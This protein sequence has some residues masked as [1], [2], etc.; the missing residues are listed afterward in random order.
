MSGGG[1]GKH[2]L[3]GWPLPQAATHH[4]CCLI[5]GVYR[6]R[7][8]WLWGRTP[9]GREG[10][11]FECV[12]GWEKASCRGGEGVC[13]LG[14]IRQRPKTVEQEETTDMYLFDQTTSC[15]VSP[16]SETTKH[17]QVNRSDCDWLH[18]LSN[19]YRLGPR[20]ASWASLFYTVAPR[21]ILCVYHQVFGLN[22]GSFL[23]LHDD[24]VV[25]YNLGPKS[26]KKK[27]PQ[28]VSGLVWL[29]SK[30]FLRF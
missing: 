15:V 7:V 18:S 13:T 17:S 2:R 6:E 10:G 26:Q 14:K 29:T 25:D 30:L 28:Q 3:T 22:L 16:W 9:G 5:R 8:G 1:R 19:C 12:N 24:R 11:E 20:A 21:M 27:K 23:I 4:T